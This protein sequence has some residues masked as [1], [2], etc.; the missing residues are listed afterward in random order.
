MLVSG[1]VVFALLH[2]FPNGHGGVGLEPFVGGIFMGIAFWLR[3]SLAA[4]TV[5]HAAGNLY[6]GVAA[7]V[8][9][10]A[11]AHWPH[12]FEAM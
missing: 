9:A 11:R 10:S 5:V 8:Y 12:G 6:L 3:R 2:V 1:G 4:A 7:L